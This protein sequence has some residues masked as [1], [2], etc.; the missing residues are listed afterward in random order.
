MTSNDFHLLL[1]RTAFSCMACD[2]DI[3]KREVELIKAFHHE[4]QTFGNL[5]IE[6]ELESLLA[7]INTEGYQFLRNFVQQ[8]AGSE[9]DAQQ[10]LKLVEVA[11]DTI[12]ADDKI[13]YSEIKFFKVIRAK[14]TIS[15][16]SIMAAHPDFEEYLE[17]DIISDSYVNNLQDI[18]SVASF[19]EFSNIG[20][21]DSKVLK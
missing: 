2:G 10:E 17:E 19:S 7:A 14:L 1:L 5:D 18:F 6:Q 8:L 12:K 11:I 4:Q 13:E 21:F 15:N 16:E 9:L 20:N 3:D